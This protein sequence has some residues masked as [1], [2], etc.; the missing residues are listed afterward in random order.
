MNERVNLQLDKKGHI[1]FK[2]FYVHTFKNK[3][4]MISLSAII[5]KLLSL[6]PLIQLIQ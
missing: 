1:W 6:K 3:F 2:E 4:M 5:P